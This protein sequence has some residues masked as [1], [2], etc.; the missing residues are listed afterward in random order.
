M[1]GAP[2]FMIWTYLSNA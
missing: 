1:V 2:S